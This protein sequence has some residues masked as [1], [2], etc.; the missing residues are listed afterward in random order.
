MEKNKCDYAVKDITLAAQGR[1]LI[2]MTEDE[3]PGLMALRKEYGKKKPLKGARIMGSMHMTCETA[4]LIETLREL[5][6][7]L[8]WASSNIFSTNDAAAAAIAQADSTE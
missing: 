2:E 5:G 8:R 3:M 4:V 1:R 7:S 6:A